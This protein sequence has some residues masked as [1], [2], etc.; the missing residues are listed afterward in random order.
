MLQK[1]KKIGF[2]ISA[3]ALMLL[4]NCAN[5]DAGVDTVNLGPGTGVG[6]S[7]ARFSIV[8]NYMYILGS[9]KL[10]VIDLTDAAQPEEV[11]ESAIPDILETI[12]N[13]GENLFIGAQNGM[14]VYSL[15]D[16]LNPKYI[17]RFTHQTACDPVITNGHIAYL[18]IRNGQSCRWNTLNRLIAVDIS[19]LE[20]P[21]QSFSI[22]MENPRG[23]AIYNG[24]LY[25]GEGSR[26][27][28][29]FDLT[30]PYKPALDTFYR[31]IP[32]NDLIG[33]PTKLLITESN[34][35]SQFELENDSLK[36]LSKIF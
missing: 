10:R 1:M 19:D 26:G 15:A 5:E 11:S 13:D 14:Y 32:C 36:L 25:V 27:L 21:I 33:L 8:G 29:K 23:L 6:G 20:N 30:N 16:P 17:S 3:M 9:S 18:T 28:K 12:Y 7:S 34:G 35:V 31:S 4:C 22:A 2:I 24:S